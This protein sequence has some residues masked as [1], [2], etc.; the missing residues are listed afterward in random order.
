MGNTFRAEITH[1][2]APAV[3]QGPGK[4]RIR[5]KDH[6]TACSVVLGIPIWVI[7]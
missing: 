6:P 5:F 1:R 2:G 4:D 3:N 7:P